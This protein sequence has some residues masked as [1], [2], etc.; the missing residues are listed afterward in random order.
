MATQT[1][2]SSSLPSYTQAPYTQASNEQA[3]NEQPQYD[4]KR[5]LAMFKGEFPRINGSTRLGKTEHFGPL[6]VQRPFYP[7][8]AECL[9]L[10]LLHP[11]GGLV[12]GD[13]LSISFDVLAGAHLLMTTPSAGKMYRNI[14]DQPQGQQVSITVK[15]NAVMEYFPQ[16]NI[17][18][19]G[20]NGEL[21][22]KV[23]IAEDG[24]FI[25]WEITCLGLYENQE[26]FTEGQLKQELIIT[27]SGKPLFID[28]FHVAAPNRLQ[29]GKTGL[30]NKSVN[31]IFVINAEVNA[32]EITE[33]ILAWQEQINH[34]DVG[35]TTV[36]ITQK[37]EL[38][39]ARVLSNKAEVVRQHF[40]KLWVILRPYIIHREACAPRIWL[41]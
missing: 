40:E 25:G 6:R 4:A 3:P 23:D 30:Q 36:A 1:I 32:P 18:F 24:L 38:F 41:T 28:R 34:S 12:G 15:E 33:L 11:P 13:N 8:G 21:S 26:P 39:I 31:G 29:Q 27:Q 19:N 35:E 2:Y 10:Y 20:A 14:S 7:E 17:V 16:E 5:W 37:P 9:H 22:T